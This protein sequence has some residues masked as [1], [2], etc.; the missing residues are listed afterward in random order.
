MCVG[1][2]Q[3]VASLGRHALTIALIAAAAI[4]VVLL[5]LSLFIITVL[6]VWVSR[7]NKQLRIV[8]GMTLT[9]WELCVTDTDLI[10]LL[11]THFHLAVQSE[12]Q[13]I[14]LSGVNTSPDDHLKN[15]A[16]A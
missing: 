16:Y 9:L 15:S 10:E 12:T 8:K 13:A 4:L 7:L 5:L 11:Y 6:V 1:G 3:E 14:L 2:T